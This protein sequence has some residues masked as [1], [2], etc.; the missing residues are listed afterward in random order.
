MTY[1]NP[2]GTETRWDKFRNFLAWLPEA[3]RV[4]LGVFLFVLSAFRRKQ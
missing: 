2:D 1:Q 3:P 4:I